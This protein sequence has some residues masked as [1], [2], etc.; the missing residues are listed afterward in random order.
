MSAKTIT[1][2]F[3][4]DQQAWAVLAAALFFVLSLAWFYQ[5]GVQWQW[6]I[7]HPKVFLL[8]VL[9]YPILEELIFRGWLQGVMLNY[10][11]GRW[12]VSCLSFSN[13]LCSIIFVLFHHA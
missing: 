12:Y 4:V 13:L 5:Q 7:Q 9:V 2:R 11:W 8:L 3:F 6:P 1:C 10:S